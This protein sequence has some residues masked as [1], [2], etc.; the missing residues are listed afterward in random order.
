MLNTSGGAKTTMPLILLLFITVY[1]SLQA[2]FYIRV[3]AAFRPSPLVRR[4]ILLGLMIPIFSPFWSRYLDHVGVE[5]PARLAGV[6]GYSWLVFV[7]WFA[8]LSMLTFAWNLALKAVE[9]RVPSAR[10]FQCP[11][12]TSVVYSL[13]IIA[14]AFVWGWFEGQ[15]IEIREVFISTPRLEVSARPI[16]IAQISDMHLG[17]PR[18]TR[19]AERIA[20]LLNELNP[21]LVVSTGDLVDSTSLADHP[22]ADALRT[23][24][25][26]LGKVAVLGNH[27][28]YTGLRES[29]VFHEASGFRVL[30][31]ESVRVT[32]GLTLVGVDDDAARYT[33][34]GGVTD[35]IPALA[36]VNPNDFIILLKHQPKISGRAVGYFDLQ[37]SG[38]THGGQV[39]PF[40]LLVRLVYRYRAGMFR[41]SDRSLL[42]VNKGTGVWGVPIRVMARPE[43]TVFILSPAE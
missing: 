17:K 28:Y 38:H 42:Y 19:F 24:Q 43:I 40:G 3:C 13:A 6:A 23:V 33:G 34:Q 10:R 15:S 21:D 18:G 12:R 8:C 1:V 27:E 29:L 14:A 31:G 16:R 9:L 30:R 2:L 5:W 25:P 35:E 11:V 36:S 39:F 20:G 41:L 7:F 32:P 22:V 37:L 4:L 26:R